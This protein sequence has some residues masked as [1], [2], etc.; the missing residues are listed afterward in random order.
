MISP[1]L[2]CTFKDIII[3]IHLL[4]VFINFYGTMWVWCESF[5]VRLNNIILFNDIYKYSL[6]LPYIWPKFTY[7][8]CTFHILPPLS[9]LLMEKK[10]NTICV[11]SDKLSK[12]ISSTFYPYKFLLLFLTMTIKV[13]NIL[14]NTI[15]KIWITFCRFS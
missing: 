9:F 4:F 15:Y 3:F 10:N 13:M 6:L 12:I 7:S 8:S 5:I 2:F 1:M 14:S 11:F